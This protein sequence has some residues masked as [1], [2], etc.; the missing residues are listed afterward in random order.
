M[1]RLIIP[2]SKKRYL[3]GYLEAEAFFGRNHGLYP[4]LQ[5]GSVDRDIIMFCASL[6]HSNVTVGLQKQLQHQAFYR[7]SVNGQKAIDIMEQI[8]PFMTARRSSKILSVLSQAR[9]VKRYKI[10][11]NFKIENFLNKT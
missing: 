9:E 3:A 11:T 1:K 5:V 8:L 4:T 6:F 7:T 10:P 2:E